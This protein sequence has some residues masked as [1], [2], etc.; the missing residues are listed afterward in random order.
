MN[1]CIFC[2]APVPRKE[3][4]YEAAVCEGC[5]K[6]IEESKEDCRE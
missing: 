1:T 5:E 4:S 3:S 2:G 6:K